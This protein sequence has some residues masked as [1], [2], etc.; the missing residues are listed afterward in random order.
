MPIHR[1][2]WPVFWATFA[3]VVITL[4][5]VPTQGGIFSIKQVTRVKETEFSVSTSS[6]P[7]GQQAAKLSFGYA[8]SAYGVV[9]LNET[10]PPFMSHNYTLRPFQPSKLSQKHSKSL[11]TNGTW[12][13]PT[14]MYTADL[15]CENVSH[16]ANESDNPF[17]ASS[18]DCNFTASGLDGNLTIN[19]KD[20]KTQ[21][22]ASL[23]CMSGQLPHLAGYRCSYLIHASIR[24]ENGNMADYSL[25]WRCPETANRTFFASFQRNKVRRITTLRSLQ[26]ST[27]TLI[28]SC[29]VNPQIANYYH[30]QK[31]EDDPPNGVTAVFCQTR[32][33]QQEVVATVDMITRRPLLIKPMSNEEKLTD[34]MFNVTVFETLLNAMVLR[35]R[36][37]DDVLPMSLIPS[38]LGPIAD[39]DIS[40]KF[41]GSPVRPLVGMSILVGRQPLEKYLDWQILSK[42]YADA[43]RLFFSR[44]IAEVMNVT[45]FSWKQV[46][47]QQDFHSESVVMEPVFVYIVEG[48]L[49]LVSISTIFLLYITFVRRENLYS[50]PGTIAGIMSLV[51]DHSSLLIS[52][53]NLDSCTLD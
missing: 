19:A 25:D 13:A 14:T 31:N 5:V 10:L 27:W 47:G 20:E 52:F 49:G 39:M 43:H 21:L 29:S 8:Q 22:K 9:S 26:R 34:D 3:V 17:Y 16:A 48:L 53:E 46:T 6:I 40:P 18:R 41:V 33:W 35:Y 37:R 12:K 23:D 32:Y 24:Y 28:Y 15:Y 2:H 7:T 45:S 44:A 30:F 38:Y 4:G 1:R 11:T 51:A 50:D 42:A 36:V